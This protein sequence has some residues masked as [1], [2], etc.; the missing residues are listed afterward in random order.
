MLSG[1]DLLINYSDD[2]YYSSIEEDV[3]QNFDININDVY[4]LTNDTILELVKHMDNRTFKR[5]CMTNKKFKYL[6]ERDILYPIVNENIPEFLL[7]LDLN[8]LNNLSL[9]N[10]RI[11]NLIRNNK[12][13]YLKLEKDFSHYINKWLLF[14]NQSYLGKIIYQDIVNNNKNYYLFFMQYENCIYTDFA[15]YSIES[16]RNMID[17]MSFRHIPINILLM[18]LSISYNDVN[19]EKRVKNY[20]IPLLSNNTFI[21]TFLNPNSS[22][23]YFIKNGVLIENIPRYGKFGIKIDPDVNIPCIYKMY[24]NLMSLK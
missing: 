4:I 24:K 7:L 9:S 13:W 21:S 22:F 8:T 3:K 20:N 1:D 15:E 10:R 11:N 17:A 18:L 6:C 16:I 12:F 23:S 14:K 5:F 2:E 19:V